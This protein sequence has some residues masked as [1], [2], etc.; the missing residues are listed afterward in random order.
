MG[1]KLLYLCIIGHF[2]W[3][4]TVQ[5]AF[6]QGKLA[7]TDIGKTYRLPTERLLPGLYWH[8]PEN[9]SVN[10]GNTSIRNSLPH[11]LSWKGNPN[12]N[13]YGYFQRNR[14]LG[15]TFTVDQNYHVTL[16]A[17]VLRTSRGNNAIMDGTPGAQMYVVFFEVRSKPGQSFRINENGTTKG[18]RA[19]HGFD[20]QFNRAD[21]FV[22]GAEYV[23][24]RSFTGG[25]FPKIEPTTQ[26]VY[27]NKNGKPYGEQPGHLRYFRCDF[28]NDTLLELKAGKKYAFMIGFL[29]PGVDLGLALAISTKVHTK[30][31]A[32]FVKDPLGAIWW[33]LRR[34]GNGVTP[35]TMI[36]QAAPPRD[37]ALYQKLLAEAMFEPDHYARLQPTTDG[38]PDVDTYRTLQFYL[39]LAGKRSA[40]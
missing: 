29:H 24:L 23:F 4:F 12:G 36:G 35:P 1:T 21:D 25:V 19:T 30:E 39:E 11:N 5:P 3:A 2:L 34:E 22:E 9:D 17:L 20:L 8:I 31:A 26:Y 16:D 13:G 7:I 14:D 10:G 27:D 37:S 15:Q 38:Y 33:G 18:Q 6:A 40:H 32:A 28:D